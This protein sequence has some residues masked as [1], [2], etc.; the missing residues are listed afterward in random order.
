MMLSRFWMGKKMDK[1][2]EQAPE[3]ATKTPAAE[4]TNVS[5]SLAN[6]MAATGKALIQEI[7]RRTTKDRTERVI[8]ILE[9]EFRLRNEAQMGISIATLQFNHY[10]KVFEAIENG[11]FTITPEGVVL[12][13]DPS[14]VLGRYQPDGSVMYGGVPAKK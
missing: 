5:N 6:P 4:A 14:L 13:N 8:T 9:Q 7:V 3:T 11:E 10:S 1:E 2:K 12:M